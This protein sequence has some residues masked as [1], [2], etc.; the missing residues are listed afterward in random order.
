MSLTDMST[1]QSRVKIWSIRCFGEKIASDK[2]ERNHRFLEES[3]ELVQSLGC[4]KSEAYQLVDYV[5][6]RLKGEAEQECG[7]VQVT[8][9]ALCN[10]NGLD[11]PLCA[12]KELMRTIQNIE[13]IRAKQAAKPAHS[14]L[15]VILGICGNYDKPHE[16]IEDCVGWKSLEAT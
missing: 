2:T 3:L 14:P 6:D 12:E 13:K 16:K 8:L 10:A 11:M 1:F 9:A 7:G 4:T 15:P 5:F